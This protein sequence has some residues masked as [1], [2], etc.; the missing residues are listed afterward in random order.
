[1]LWEVDPACLGPALKEL[2]LLGT[3]HAIGESANLDRPAPMVELD[4]QKPLGIAC[5]AAA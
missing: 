2:S 1:L 4:R 5:G 3:R